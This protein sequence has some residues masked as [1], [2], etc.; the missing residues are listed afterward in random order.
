MQSAGTHRQWT[1][2]THTH[3]RTH[4]R[5]HAR[6]HAHTAYIA[7]H[8][9]K[10]GVEQKACT[11]EGKKQLCSANQLRQIKSKITA[12]SSMV[13]AAISLFQQTN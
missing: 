6:T 9:Y 7:V 13:G 1:T 3:A 4:T 8:T 10:V 12:G 5:T 2:H 11:E